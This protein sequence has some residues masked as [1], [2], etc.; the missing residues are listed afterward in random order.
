VAPV[1]LWLDLLAA[2]WPDERAPSLALEGQLGS[3][4]EVD[5]LCLWPGAGVWSACFT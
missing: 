5:S 1:F 4:G 3:A 2:R